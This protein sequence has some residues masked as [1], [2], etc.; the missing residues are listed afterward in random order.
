MTLPI[1]E[2]E[3]EN[4]GR[5]FWENAGEVFSPPYDITRAIAFS[6]PLDV[7]LIAGLSMRNIEAW[8]R[9]RGA[10][11]RFTTNSRAVRGC[12]LVNRGA[13]MIFVDACDSEDERRYTVAHETA[14]FLIEYW[15]PRTTAVREFGNGIQDVLD[16]KRAPEP[17]ERLESILLNVSLKPYVSLIEREGNGFFHR[18]EV[19]RAE[20][21]AD[22]LAVELLAPIAEVTS[23]LRAQGVA[24]SFFRCNSEAQRMLTERFCL[25]ATIT[26]SYSRR[27][28][29][30][31]TGGAP[32]L[33]S[34]GL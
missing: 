15:G 5:R 4:L 28:A 14:H 7:A 20:N 34:W 23:C 1:I 18:T 17:E 3:L 25:P 32:V 31:L 10:D 8:L 12:L 19:W 16:G 33:E 24:D 26:R 11:Y 21:R 27:I 13:G 22:R 2:P 29:E 6:L 9:T 30:A